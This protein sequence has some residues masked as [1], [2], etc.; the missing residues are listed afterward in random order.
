M[1]QHELA[2]TML[3]AAGGSPVE[4]RLADD[5]AGKR[6]DILF[7]AER[8]IVEVKSFTSHRAEAYQVAGKMGEMLARNIHLGAPVLL[9]PTRMGLH[10][11]PALV[12]QKALRILGKRVRKEVSAARDQI[13]AT[14]AALLLPEAFGLLLFISPPHRIGQQSIAWLV[15]DL[16]ALG[17]D[18]TGLDGILMIETAR[19]TGTAGPRPPSFLSFWTISGRSL[20]DVLKDRIGAAWGLVTGE[21]GCHADVDDFVGL[22][23]SE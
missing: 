18:L 15:A 9:G 7:A 4:A 2:V 22:G 13:A 16:R 1:D 6:A 14:R 17:H 20:P 19:G 8:V 11:L 23:A 12:A 5:Y 10:D 21:Q 3:R